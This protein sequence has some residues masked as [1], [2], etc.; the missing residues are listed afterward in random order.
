MPQA[1]RCE[2]NQATSGVLP[3]PPTVR[4]PTTITGAAT[5]MRW[6]SPSRYRRLRTDMTR[7]YNSENGTSQR[8]ADWLYHILS[9]FRI[10]RLT[11]EFRALEAGVC[12]FTRD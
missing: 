7:P 1:A 2:D 11:A 10:E 12:T 3:V 4:L 8:G 9:I 5:L 6:R